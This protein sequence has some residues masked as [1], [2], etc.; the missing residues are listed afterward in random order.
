MSMPSD[1]GA[2][3]DGIVYRGLRRIIDL[4]PEEA[5]ALAWSWLYVFALFLAYSVLRP[6]RDE[7]GVAGGTANLGWLFTGTLLA[8]LL[9]NPLYSSL[10][11]R[12][13]R[14][15]F[16]A[17]SYRFFMANL[18]VFFVLLQVA[19]PDQ[20]IWIGR[21]FFIWISVFNLFVVSVFWSFVVDFFGT[22]QGKRLFGFLATGATVGGIAGASVTSLLVGLIGQNWLLLVSVLLIE[23]SVLA[24]HRLSRFGTARRAADGSPGEERIP[25]GIF[26]GLT[27]TLRSPYLL[28]IAV[29]ILLYSVTSTFL[30]SQQAI[31]AA[32]YPSRAARTEFFAN[33]DLIVN[34]LTLVAQVF[35]TGRAIAFMGVALT[36]SVLPL[37]SV[38][39]FGALA[40]VPS[41]AVLVAAQVSRRVSN[42]ALAR[43]TREVLFTSLPREDKYKSKNFIDTVVYRTGDQLGI[44][45]AS[46]LTWSGLGM[47][48]VA[49]WAVP[50]S[51]V[52]LVVAYWLGRQQERRAALPPAIVPEHG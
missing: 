37:F 19:T 30:Y 50:I 11:R 4:R 36:L 31:A 1:S 14:E 3:G 48:G 41:V 13:S 28:G 22:E 39:G 52:W 43:P 21:A 6:I 23:V 8:M 29:F 5:G 24:V 34:V 16:I 33:I 20:H 47:S 9:A 7:L 10:M 46:L 27:H 42:F 45:T 38:I 25:G 18:L 32:A 15:R 12:M 49:V 40:A 17:I 26:A 2:G 35:L 51:V 44:W